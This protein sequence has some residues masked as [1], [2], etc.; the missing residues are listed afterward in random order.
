MSERAD[1]IAL[2]QG[3]DMPFL[4]CIICLQNGYSIRL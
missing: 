2:H 3:S 1:W 4:P